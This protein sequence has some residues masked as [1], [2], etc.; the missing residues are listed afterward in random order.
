M[1]VASLGCVLNAVGV[2]LC[3]L[4][5]GIEPIVGADITAR[6]E[7]NVFV[8]V[9]LGNVITVH[10]VINHL[11][12]LSTCKR[13]IVPSCQQFNHLVSDGLLFCQRLGFI[14]CRASGRNVYNTIAHLVLLLGFQGRNGCFQAVFGI[15]TVH[16]CGSV[17]ACNTFH[18]TALYEVLEVVDGLVSGKA[19]L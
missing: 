3:L 10:I 1:A 9:L 11:Q 14:V 8:V 13:F 19:F 4:A 12:S 2:C 6:T 17:C 7:L 5:N 16:S 18:I 15:D